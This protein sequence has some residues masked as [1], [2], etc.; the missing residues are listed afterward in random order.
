MYRFLKACG[1]VVSCCLSVSAFA[2]FSIDPI[3]DISIAE[4]RAYTSAAPQ[5][6]GDNLGNISFSLM[7][8]DASRFSLSTNGTVTLLAQDF[9]NPSDADKNNSYLVT[10]IAE[11]DDARTDSTSWTVTVTDQDA[12]SF[13][14]KQLIDATLMEGVP[15]ISEAVNV[16][17]RFVGN[18]HYQLSGDDALVFNFNDSTR[19]LTLGTQDFENPNDK[20]T[21][22]IYAVTVT[23]IDSDG[24]EDSTS[25]LITI[26]DQYDLD[27]DGD[28]VFDSVELAELTNPN[29]ITDYLDSDNDLIPDALDN[30]SDNDTLADAVESNGIEPH[31]D[32]D[33][34]G[35]PNYLDQDNRGDGQSAQCSTN[36]EQLGVCQF[37]Q[38]L[39]PLFDFDQDGKPN[40]G[41]K[42][43]DNDHIP[44]VI[45]LDGDSDGDGDSDYMDI[46]SDNDGIPDIIESRTGYIDSDGDGIDDIFDADFSGIDN[47]ADNIKDNAKAIDSDAD[48]LPD[49]LDTDSDN[50]RIPDTLEAT[51]SQ[52]SNGNGIDDAFDVAYTGG[53][54]SNND[55]IDDRL[56]TKQTH[57]D[58]LPNYLDIDSDQD[59]ISDTIESGASG[60]DI[61]NNGIDDA[62]DAALTSGIDNNADGIIEHA[63]PDDDG[64]G[65]ANLHDLDADND[66]IPDV[67]ESGGSD[68]NR[69]GLSDNGNITPQ[70]LIDTDKDSIPDYLDITHAD[71]SFTILSGDFS[72]FDI[73]ADGRVDVSDDSDKDGV[74][75]SIDTQPT[76][77]GLR[78]IDKDNDGI[79]DDLDPDNDNDGISNIIEGKIDTDGDGITNDFDPDSDNDGISDFIEATYNSKRLG[80]DNNNGIDDSIDVSIVGGKDSNQD[81]VADRF[82]PVDFDGDGIPDYLDIDSDNDT[83]T[84]WQESS[85]K[86][87]SHNDSDRDGIDDSYDADLSGGPDHN[88]DGIDDDIVILPNSDNDQHPDFR[89][90]DSDNDGL[91]DRVEFEDLNADDISDH[92]QA[93]SGVKTGDSSLSGGYGGNLG[94]LLLLIASTFSRRK[95]AL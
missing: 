16:S 46:D 9:E 33:A 81:G 45:E 32:A 28:G 68:N 21:D 88:I 79:S 59:G 3:A 39:D 26:E 1:A 47:N 24:Q 57:N 91:P 64:D 65:A 30:D 75:N 29:D 93:E 83:L 95:E 74:D 38:P 71:G 53:S 69:D 89:D 37:G 62:F 17:G 60:E 10:L 11:T 14:I 25:I 18:I 35:I 36:K 86:E 19:Q 6:T 41:D 51:L 84:D 43:S 13:T 78:Q 5:I 22:N 15:Y 87:P 7:G 8:D 55:H 85:A 23:A 72:E 48:G 27:S 92:Q 82:H 2:A 80:D 73:D 20:N 67:D 76:L 44:D 66:G 63:L 12:S 34:D 49:Y 31:G 52:D 4:N 77:Y 70:P 61:N 54:D 50:D 94:F 42:D 56:H 58:G 40:H 90:I